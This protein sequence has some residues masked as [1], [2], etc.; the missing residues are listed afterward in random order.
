MDFSDF[1]EEYNIVL[2]EDIYWLDD[3]YTSRNDVEKAFDEVYQ[4]VSEGDT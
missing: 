1:L 2:E 4:K 3:D